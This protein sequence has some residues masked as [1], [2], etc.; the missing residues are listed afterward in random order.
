MKQTATGIMFEFDKVTTEE[1]LITEVAGAMSLHCQQLQA[2]GISQDE[3][4]EMVEFITQT[5]KTYAAVYEQL[6]REG[7]MKPYKNNGETWNKSDA[8]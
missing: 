8:Q 4:V 3:A 5:A 6:V 7:K 2:H 1:E